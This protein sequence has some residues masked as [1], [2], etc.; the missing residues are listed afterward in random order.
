MHV[1]SWLSACVTV[2]EEWARN[3]RNVATSAHRQTKAGDVSWSPRCAQWRVRP[4]QFCA[5]GCCLAVCQLWIE[6][7]RSC[8]TG[9]GLLI[10]QYDPKGA[11]G[12]PR[13]CVF[14]RAYRAYSHAPSRFLFGNRMAASA[15]PTRVFGCGMSAR[16]SVPCRLT[17]LVRSNKD[18]YRF[19]FPPH[20]LRRPCSRRQS[21]VFAA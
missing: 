2:R 9:Q 11:L 19:R 4:G 6:W 5:R 10:S 15:R 1:A 13:L 16:G 3:N 17:T 14:G 20:R 21:Q 8:D 12:C 7:R 18:V